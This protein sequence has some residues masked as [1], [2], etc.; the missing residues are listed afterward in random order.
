MPLLPAEQIA[1]FV[2]ALNNRA[3]LAFI[4]L[5]RKALGVRELEKYNDK[6][7]DD[8]KGADF[9]G[10][11]LREM[12]VDFMISGAQRLRNLPEGPFITV[13]NHPYGAIDGIML[14]DIFGHQRPEFKVMV[15]EFLAVVEGL[16]PSMIQVN[17]KNDSNN[18]VT[19]L[20]LNGVREVIS[21]INEGHPIGFFPSGAVSDLHLRDRKIYDRQW[22]EPVIRLIK[23]ARVPVV[24]V[25]FFGR[26]SL[27]FYLLGL[28]DWRVRVL[29]LPRELANQKGKG[30][31]IVVGIGETIPVDKQKEFTDI[32]EYGQMLRDSVYGMEQDR[33][34]V[35]YSEFLKGTVR[36]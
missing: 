23:K 30:N 12:D 3:G 10:A 5:L 15:N 14:I 22:Q 21:R 20:N 7:I 17:P 9:A 28:I 26:N 18:K 27:F 24:P 31:G 19:S 6:I 33:E 11:L 29:R 16:T 8:N 25:R 32:N 1:G 34:L 2:P 4:E 36:Q 13:S 35:R